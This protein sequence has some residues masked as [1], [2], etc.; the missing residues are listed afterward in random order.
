VLWANADSR[1]TLEQSYGAL[2]ALLQLPESSEQDQ[3]RV[4][5][6]VRRWLATNTSWLLILDNAD[7]IA[8]VRDFLPATHQGHVLL[9]T[10]AQALADIAQGLSVAPMGV[11]EGA[12]L[13][14]RRARKL[15]LTAP[16]DVANVSEHNAAATLAQEFDGLPLALDQAGAYCEETGSTIAGYLE[17]YRSQRA[18]LLHRRGRL[19]KEHPQSVVATFALAFEKVREH[20]EGAADLLRLCAFLQPDT[21]PEELFLEAA[22]ELGLR[23]RE[24]ASDPLALDEAIAT[25]HAYSLVRG[26]TGTQELAM[27]RLVQAVLRDNM[28]KKEQR[29]WAVRAVRAIAHV[30]PD[31]EDV[32]NWPRCQRYIVQAQ[33]CAD[34]V[35]Q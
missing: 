16:L 21:I 34:L 11:E 35:A 28:G 24:L 7:E 27:H 22:P 15:D 6:A 13:L 17:R 8:I 1:E 31:A 2:A 12:L 25:L 26:G 29:K 23:L 4:I 10:R 32:S 19:A 14:L 33:N 3:S 20:N 9:T 5:A 30:F 18:Q